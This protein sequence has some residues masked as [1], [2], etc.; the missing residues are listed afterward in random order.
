MEF[1]AAFEN[2]I[3]SHS[4]LHHLCKCEYTYM[5]IYCCDPLLACVLLRRIYWA[6]LVGHC[7]VSIRILSCASE[8]GSPTNHQG[9]RQ[10]QDKGPGILWSVHRWTK[11]NT[12][13]GASTITWSPW[14]GCMRQYIF[15][16]SYQYPTSIQLF[17]VSADGRQTKMVA[18]L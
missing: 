9:S 7:V 10:R 17:W 15:M 6:F 16:H 3:H 1:L 8:V 12:Y 11:P 4:V 13:G 5:H 18:S 14:V 2:L